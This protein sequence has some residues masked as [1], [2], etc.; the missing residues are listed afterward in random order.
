MKLILHLLEDKNFVIKYEKVIKIV[1]HTFDFN[2][3]YEINETR[4]EIT[5]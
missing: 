1:F 5:L 3:T 4:T 2:F